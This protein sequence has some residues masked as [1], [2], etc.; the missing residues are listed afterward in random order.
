[1]MIEAQEKL[2]PRS[3]TP[4]H[5]IDRVT[6]GLTLCCTNVGIARLIQSKIDEGSVEKLYLAKVQGNFIASEDSANMRLPE[7]SKFAHWSWQKDTDC[8]L[9]D[10]PVHTLDAQNGIREVSPQGKPS[11]SRFQF[12]AYD[13]KENT[14]LIACCPLT[15]RGHQL[16]V[17]LKWLGFPIANDTQYGGLPEKCEYNRD[18]ILSQMMSSLESESNRDDSAE[19][20]T[21]AHDDVEA[22]KTACRCCQQGKDGFVESFTP[23][24]LLERGHSICLHALRYKIPIFLKKNKSKDPDEKPAPLATIEAEVDLPGWAEC[25]G[26]IGPLPC[27]H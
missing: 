18:A 9:V 20:T 5:R 22:A 21:I 8:V 14:S 26:P 27:L 16:R 2:E 25:F 17:H 7:N 19:K 24:Q 4:C 12:L 11:R 10:A 13:N 3:L 6:S 23:A 1:M 15:G